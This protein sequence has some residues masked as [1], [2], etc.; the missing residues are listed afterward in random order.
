MNLGKNVSIRRKTSEFCLESGTS[1]YSVSV[2]G[3]ICQLGVLSSN[4]WYNRSELVQS[5]DSGDNLSSWGTI[6]HSRVQ[7]V[8][9]RVESLNWAWK[10]T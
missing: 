10:H 3:A 5:V 6:C 8:Q 4:L 1:G 9:F 7:S 2:M